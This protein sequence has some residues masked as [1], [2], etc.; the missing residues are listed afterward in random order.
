MNHASD[1]AVAS[2]TRAGTATTEP[3]VMMARGPC[4]SS[5]LP[6]GMPTSAATIWLAE[7]PAV[8]AASDHPVRALIVGSSTGN[9]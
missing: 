8:I 1:C 3:V 5:N 4:R 6:T 7:N 2:P 9:A